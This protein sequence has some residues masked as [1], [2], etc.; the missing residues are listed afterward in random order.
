MTGYLLDTTPLSAYL[1][2]RQAA[3][4]R[5]DPWLARHE[6]ATSLLV[7][8]EVVEALRSR[9]TFP[10]LHE[11]LR[12]LLVEIQ[13]LQLDYPVLDRYSLIRRQLRPPHGPGLIGDIDTLIAA[14]AIENNL[15]IVTCD[16][17]FARVPDL[18][19]LLIPR[20]EFS[21]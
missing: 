2:G 15:T 18:E 9:A 17:D 16:T 20:A 21:R 1:S 19:T 10:A 12:N 4:E 11:R 3:I 8:A 13:P 5:F 6:L 7:Y 14:T